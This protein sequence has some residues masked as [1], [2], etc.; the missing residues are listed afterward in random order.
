[1]ELESMHEKR[2]KNG[3]IAVNVNHLSKTNRQETGHD[4]M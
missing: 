1:M 4:V 3:N 2:K